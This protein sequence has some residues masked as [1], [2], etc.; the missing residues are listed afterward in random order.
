MR[1]ESDRWFGAAAV[2][3]KIHCTAVVKRHLSKK[4]K[5]SIHQMIYMS[6]SFG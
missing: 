3:Q 6:M 2:I 1:P 5:L 4:A